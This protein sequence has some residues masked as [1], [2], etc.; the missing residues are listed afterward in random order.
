MRKPNFKS[1]KDWDRRWLLLAELMASFSK[2][3]S[4]KVGA[5]AVRDRR[6]L[7]TGFNGMPTGVV[8]SSFRLNDRDVR[9]SMTVHAEMNVINFA[10]RNGVS[11]MGSDLFIFPLAPCSS[12][13]SSIIQAGVRRVIVYDYVIPRRWQQSFDTAAEMFSESGVALLR[14]PEKE[15]KEPEE[16]VS[17]IGSKIPPSLRDIS[18]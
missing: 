14:L 9:L 6:V 8:D 3:P 13:A 17:N 10:A 15:E 5:V 1:P 11:L 12:C 2:D 7:S 16:D 18:A 4:T